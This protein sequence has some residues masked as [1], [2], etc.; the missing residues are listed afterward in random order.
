MEVV[1]PV[2]TPRSLGMEG[3]AAVGCIL[4]PTRIQLS[5][6][7]ILQKFT[8]EPILVPHSDSMACSLE[9]HLQGKARD[10]WDPPYSLSTHVCLTNLT[11]GRTMA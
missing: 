2:M 10:L 3:N 11:K 9:K 6:L 4:K 5:W 8:V 7:D 1:P